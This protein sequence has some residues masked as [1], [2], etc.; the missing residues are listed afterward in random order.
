MERVGSRITVLLSE[1][2]DGQMYEILAAE[3]CDE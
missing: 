1:R 3:L 2:K